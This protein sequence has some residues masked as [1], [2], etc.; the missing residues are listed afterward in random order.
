[1]K[2]SF[3]G[4]LRILFLRPIMLRNGYVHWLLSFSRNSV[5]KNMYKKI[6]ILSFLL[7]K[8]LEIWHCL[9]QTI[10][11]VTV[12]VIIRPSSTGNSQE[13]SQGLLR[14]QPHDSHYHFLEAPK[15]GNKIL[16]WIEQSLG[17]CRSCFTSSTRH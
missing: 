6:P 8:C 3:W 15:K 5:V 7:R 2:K 14:A 9:Y 16:K 13:L 11:S 12:V 17:K 4:L 1:M 10:L